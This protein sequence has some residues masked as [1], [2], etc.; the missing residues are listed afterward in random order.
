MLFLA[1]AEHWIVFFM[2]FTPVVVVIGL[3]IWK[4]RIDRRADALLH[5]SPAAADPRHQRSD[6]P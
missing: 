5:A 2:E 4:W 3:V 6:Q 1:H